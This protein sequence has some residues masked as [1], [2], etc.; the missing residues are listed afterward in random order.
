MPALRSVGMTL[1]TPGQKCLRFFLHSCLFVPTTEYGRGLAFLTWARYFPSRLT[2]LTMLAWGKQLCTNPW[3]NMCKSK[4]EFTLS[5]LIQHCQG[6]WSGTTPQAPAAEMHSPGNPIL[7]ANKQESLCP[8][9]PH[10]SGNISMPVD[11]QSPYAAMRKHSPA[12][13]F[14]KITYVRVMRHVRWPPCPL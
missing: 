6:D 13:R 3:G 8:S 5:V 11:F 4:A 12:L 7:G 9:K 14:S 1:N 2:W 10:L